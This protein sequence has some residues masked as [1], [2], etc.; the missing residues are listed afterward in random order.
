MGRPL[1]KKYFGNRNIGSTSTTS[2]D[3]IGGNRLASI[4]LGTAG[5]GYSQGTTVTLSAPTLPGGVTATATVAISARIA[6][7]TGGAFTAYTV[8]EKGSGYVTA[9]TVTVNKPANVTIAATGNDTEF[10]LTMTSTAGI[11][12]GM[13]VTGSTGLGTG[14][15]ANTVIVASVDSNTQVTVLTAHDGAVSA[16]LTFSDVGTSAV[17]GARTL[18]TDGTTPYAAGTNENAIVVYAYIPASG[19]LGYIS[20]AGGSSAVLSDI[21]SQTGRSKYHVKNAQGQGIVKLKTSGAANAAGEATITATDYTGTTYYVSKISAHRATLVRYGGGSYEFA[22]D[23]SV[24]WT[25]DTLV[26]GDT[27]VRVKLDNV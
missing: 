7:G 27:G 6:D 3:G 10:T 18:E 20:G 24:P 14:S 5:S 1:N 19:S 25:F 15:A 2:D 9:P 12:A 17:A 26:V 22:S 11:F 8:V 16:S 23:T 13:T 4:A 21:V